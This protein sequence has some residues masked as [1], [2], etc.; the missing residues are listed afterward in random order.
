MT[1]SLEELRALVPPA[2]V[3]GD[4]EAM[5]D[6]LEASIDQVDEDPTVIFTDDSLFA[7]AD[8]HALA[9]GLDDCA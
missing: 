1:T 7:D 2:D 4:V 9:L 6:S 3:A 8:A 5:L